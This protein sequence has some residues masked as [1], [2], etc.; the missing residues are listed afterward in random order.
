MATI[1]I[2]MCIA[3][4]ALVTT[5][6]GHSVTNTTVITV[7]VTMIHLVWYVINPLKVSCFVC[8]LYFN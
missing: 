2:K 4:T 3:T 5:L 8:E 6:V 1:T 7:V